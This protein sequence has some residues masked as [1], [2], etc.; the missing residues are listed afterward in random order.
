MK[1]KEQIVRIIQSE[2]DE[3]ETKMLW[4]QF[5]NENDLNALFAP[6]LENIGFVLANSTVTVFLKNSSFRDFFNDWVTRFID[7]IQVNDTSEILIEKFNIEIKAIVLLGQKEKKMSMNSAKGLYAEFLVLK[8][9]LDEGNY[10]QSEVLDGWHRPAPANHDFDYKSFSLEVKATA[11][12]S[13]TIKITSEHQLMAIED[14]PLHIHLYRIDN[15]NKSNEDSL[16]ELYL[17]IKDQLDTGLVNAFEMKC[18]EDSFCEYLGPEHMPLDYKFMTIEDFLYDVE[19]VLFPRIR[20]EA[21]DTG[22]SKISYNLDISSI[23]G[24]K[25]P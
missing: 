21:L 10:T 9:Y 17:T 1:E 2:P 20:K 7:K 12:D 11:R 13:T 22:L 3:I 4:L 14:K 16:G 23:E 6:K 5:P 19:Q 8:E 25:I 24:F 18:A 15:L